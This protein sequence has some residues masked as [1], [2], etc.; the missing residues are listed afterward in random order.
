[1]AA[2][3][4]SP[5]NLQTT[6]MYEGMQ[7]GVLDCVA[8]SNPWLKTY[9]LWDMVKSVNT[10]A[11]GTFHGSVLINFNAG[12]WQGL[13]DAERQMLLDRMPRMMRNIAEAY[14]TDDATVIEQVKEKEKGITFGP[15]ETDY[16]DAVAAQAVKDRDRV[17]ATGKDRG[18]LTPEEDADRFIALVGKWTRIVEDDRDR[19]LVGRPVAGLR[20]QGTG[21]DLLQIQALSDNRSTGQ[22]LEACRGAICGGPLHLVPGR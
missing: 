21:R 4:A 3:G 18:A 9:P 7:R 6:E 17:V 15:G 10:T 1:M 5:V 11:L 2:L 22:N 19:D 14:E 20:G 13:T 8:G 16:A 12:A